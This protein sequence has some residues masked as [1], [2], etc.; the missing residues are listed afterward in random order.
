MMLN[1]IENFLNSIMDPIKDL[2]VKDSHSVLIVL[3][4]FVGVAIFFFAYGALHKEG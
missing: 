3:L 2:L 4:F 1:S